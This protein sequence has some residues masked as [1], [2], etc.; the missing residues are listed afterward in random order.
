MTGFSLARLASRENR[1]PHAIAAR[2]ARYTAPASIDP[3]DG[4]DEREYQLWLYERDDEC[5]DE[6]DA[7]P[8]TIL[9]WC[10]LHPD[11]VFDASG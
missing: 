10:R 3:D 1:Q 2:I 7:D 11:A 9:G 5:A 8:A 4:D 6:A